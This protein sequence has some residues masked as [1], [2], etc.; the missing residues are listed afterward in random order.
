MKKSLLT[1]TFIVLFK[2]I[3][4]AQ[5]TCSSAL[6]IT[7]GINTIAQITGTEIPAQMCAT[8]GTG[9]M[10]ANWYKYSPS[11]NYS[12]TISSD[13]AANAGIDNG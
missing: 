10:A 1:L 3:S 11:Q 13:Y 12:V 5:Q 4:V 7:A 6:V 2:L 8:G 9:A